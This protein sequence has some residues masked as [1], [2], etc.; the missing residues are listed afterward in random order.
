MVGRTNQLVDPIEVLRNEMIAL[1]MAKGINDLSVLRLSQ[2][3]DQEINKY[4]Q[5]VSH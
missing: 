3:L 4:Y 1:A 5:A 2:R